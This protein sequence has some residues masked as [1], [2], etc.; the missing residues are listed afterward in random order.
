MST[1]HF[2]SLYPKYM[3]PHSD[4]LI[5]RP[6]IAVLYTQFTTSTCARC[7]ISVSGVPGSHKCANCARFALCPE[8]V[9][10]EGLALYHS[11][12]CQLFCSLPVDMRNGDTDY[13]RFVLRYFSILQHG[14]PPE[15]GACEGA[16]NKFSQL[17]SNRNIH[18][19]TFL[20][21][22]AK[23]AVLFTK[24]FTLP[25]GIT[26]S[27]LVDLFCK[28]K[29]NSLGFPFNKDET[30]GWCLDVRASM[31]NHS[32]VPNCYITNGKD[33]TMVVKTLKSVSKDEELCISYVDLLSPEF[34]EE[35]K[36]REHLFE[37]YCF[38]CQ[39][40]THPRDANKAS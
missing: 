30:M 38:W 15:S 31:F 34:S 17:C 13:L 37:T 1:L 9:K 27:D 36:R 22:T 19:K 23:F 14:I 3:A 8:C 32:C 10:I 6:D 40:E 7:F 18:S 25:K 11:H 4:V 33:G 35:Q 12:E 21:W 28:I 39:C 2:F 29:S 20:A 26:P 5:S 24:S 16:A